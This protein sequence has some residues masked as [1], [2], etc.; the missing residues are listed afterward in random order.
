VTG[1]NRQRTYGADVLSR[2]RAAERGSGEELKRLIRRDL[3]ELILR[4]TKG[5]EVAS[6]ED[7]FSHPDGGTGA[8][9][10]G[11]RS[12]GRA[13]AAGSVIE[14][15]VIAGNT[16]MEHLLLGY[17]AEGLGKWPFRPV[18]LGGETLR[19]EE[20]FGEV[21]R[22]GQERT[23]FAAAGEA[24]VLILPGCSTY[25]GADIAAGMMCAG[26]ENESTD[27][28]LLFV[29]L[30]TNGEMAVTDG[31]RIL[32]ASTACGPA[33]EGG[34]LSC[35]TGSIPGAVC[36]VRRNP[37]QQPFALLTET[38]GG[39][40]P[41]GLCGTGAIEVLDVLL[42]EGIMDAY[43]TLAEPW[44]SEGVFLDDGADGEKIVLTQADIREIQMAKGAIR[45]GI[46][47]LLSR[48]GI[49]AEELDEV[50]LAG[51][52][53][54]S[55][56]P[57]AAESCGLLPPGCAEKT[58]AAGNTSLAGAGKVLAQP[59]ALEHIRAIIEKT[60]EVTLGNEEGF[61][62]CYIRFMNFEGEGQD[63]EGRI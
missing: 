9:T 12:E 8:Q 15:I 27:R 7:G 45:A 59:D 22:D 23:A 49:R 33:L 42:K 46:E 57:E 41:V 61:S 37:A 58:R 26:M 24:E 16:T 36:H 25:I 4:L 35:G 1:L 34:K 28:K 55:L 52:F 19:A 54:C 13:P 5:G 14:K 17:P 50:I 29:D 44:F 21:L 62:E 40:T 20:L 31:R 32:A 30:G 10:E 60:E 51:G 38:I 6:P 53:G 43:G 2:I 47:I 18:S 3:A 39:G 56:D 48:A 11:D 63:D